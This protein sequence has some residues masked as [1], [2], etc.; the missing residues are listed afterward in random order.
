MSKLILGIYGAGGLGRE[1]YELA[2]L[3][4]SNAQWERIVFIDDITQG[5]C[6]NVQKYS[7]DEF[8]TTFKKGD[9]KVVIAVGE[10]AIRQMLYQKVVEAGYALE[11]LVYPTVHIPRD[12][13]LGDGIVINMGC[14]ISTDTIIEDNVFLQQYVILGHD[15]I[16]QTHSVLSAFVSVGGHSKIGS[17][18]YI[19]MHVP[20][21]EGIKI[22]DGSIVGMGSCVIRDIE[23]D[24]IALGN[25]ARP[26]RRNDKH[27]VFK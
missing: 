16:I 5:M 19:G 1:V 25:P 21:K 24:M 9:A 20:V 18:V 23:E 11:K 17:S 15:S 12:V 2:R 4:N 27:R 8:T 3:I 14:F 7:F 13:Q 22:G 26:I 6:K 10:P